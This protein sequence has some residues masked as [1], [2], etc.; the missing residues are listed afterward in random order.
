MQISN[1][2]LTLK[3]QKYTFRAYRDDQWKGTGWYRFLPPAGTMLAMTIPSRYH[4]CGAHYGVWTNSTMPTS[5]GET[6]EIFLCTRKAWKCN[7]IFPS[8]GNVTHCGEFFVYYLPDMTYTVHC[9]RKY[10]AADHY[11]N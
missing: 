4:V 11:L 3:F 10:C 5:P 1:L 7:L 6:A 2:P 8:K 9:P